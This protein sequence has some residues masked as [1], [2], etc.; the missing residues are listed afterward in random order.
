MV[1]D[2]VYQLPHVARRGEEEEGGAPLDGRLA[3]EELGHGAERVEVVAGAGQPMQAAAS[4]ASSAFAFAIAA[5]IRSSCRRVKPLELAVSAEYPALIAARVALRSIRYSSMNLFCFSVSRRLAISLLLVRQ[6]KRTGGM[7]R[8]R[9]GMK[10]KEAC[11][12]VLACVP[13]LHPNDKAHFGKNKI[14]STVS[15]IA[16]TITLLY[17]K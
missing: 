9:C 6:L 10:N 7:D 2:V 13:S 5:E 15:F 11:N 1:L 16:F 8:C 4:I 14:N 17:K 3:Q 12:E